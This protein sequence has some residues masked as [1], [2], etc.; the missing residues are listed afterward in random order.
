M[1]VSKESGENNFCYICPAQL[2]TNYK[3]RRYWSPR[4]A[5]SEDLETETWREHTSVVGLQTIV[6]RNR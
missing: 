5:D 3:Q 6:G 2:A 4:T 1:P